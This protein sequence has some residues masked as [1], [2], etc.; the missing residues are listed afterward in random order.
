MSRSSAGM[1]LLAATLTLAACGPSPAPDDDGAP[2]PADQEAF[3]EELS[4]R[5]F[6]YFW[7]TTDPATC[8]APD[9][10]PS[11]PFSSIAAVGFAITAYGIGA[12]RGYVT[13][14]QAAERTLDCLE[15][16]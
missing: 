1:G 2:P 10:W 9:R 4:R 6:D 16:F 13:R 7:E 11:A 15:Y 12:E 14:E 3:A 8:L 5:T